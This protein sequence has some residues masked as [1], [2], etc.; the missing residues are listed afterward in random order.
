MKIS[1]MGWYGRGNSGDEAFKDVHRQIFPDHDIEWLTARVTDADPDRRFVLGGGDVC[2]PFY[3]DRLPPD[4]RFWA[5]GV[6]LGGQE[7]MA[8][9]L[10]VRD[11]LRT[12]WVRNAEDAK[13]LSQK[14]VDAR[15]TPDS[16][17]CLRDAVLALEPSASAEAEIPAGR[18]RLIVVLSNNLIASGMRLGDVK[19]VSYFTF[20]K[21]ELALVLDFLAPY[22]HITFLPFSYDMNDFDMS[23]CADVIGLMK[24]RS[25][26]GVQNTR[27]VTQELSPLETIR[28]MKGAHLV[29]S[30]KFHGLIYAA[31]LGIPFVNIGLS[32]KTRM[33]CADNGFTALNVEEYC[34]SKARVAACIKAAEAADMPA[35]IAAMSAGLSKQ[36]LAAAAEFRASVL[37][38]DA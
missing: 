7:D 20:M 13:A 34:F 8:N 26:K 2:S 35:R 21:Y 14:G 38:G 37:T 25:V 22:Y 11:R 5:Y 17:F 15:Y 9:L 30:M 19:R 29:L 36:A 10:T 33:F 23:F 27:L 16:V 24:H 12:V 32:R 18:K 28:L 1:F 6:G 4:V 3:I 31:L